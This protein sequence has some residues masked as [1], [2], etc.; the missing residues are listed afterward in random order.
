MAETAPLARSRCAR[1]WFRPSVT[2]EWRA[3]ENA[4]RLSHPL[5]NEQQQKRDQQREDAERFRQ[6][7]AEEQ[8]VALAAGRRRIAQRADQEL[9]EHVG[10]ADRGAAHA[11]ARQSGAN[12]FRCYGIHEE[13]PLRETDRVKSDRA[14]N[15]RGEGSR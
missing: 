14:V 4:C 11:D 8:G 13:A 9:A 1:W 10:H 5:E 12:E 15:A 3:G 7:E 2:P 6:G